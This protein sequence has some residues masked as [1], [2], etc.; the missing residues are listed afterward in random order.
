MEY[1]YICFVKLYEAS[2]LLQKYKKY[3][4]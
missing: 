1:D 3:Q 2:D 4:P